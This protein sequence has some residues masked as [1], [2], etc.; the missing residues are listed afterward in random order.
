[1]VY[2]GKRILLS[3]WPTLDSRAPTPRP[4]AA[5]LSLTL[6]PCPHD[7][8]TWS[9]AQLWSPPSCDKGLP[10]GLCLVPV[11]QLGTTFQ[12][13]LNSPELG[14]GVLGLLPDA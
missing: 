5:P 4:K 8:A 2:V 6:P 13:H 1:M 7:V 12:D 9:P 10:T 3:G 11:P 14:L